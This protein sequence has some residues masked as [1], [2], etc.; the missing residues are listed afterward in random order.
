MVKAEDLPESGIYPYYTG[1]Y[2][3]RTYSFRGKKPGLSRD[4]Y[5]K[6]AGGYNTIKISRCRMGG[7]AHGSSGY[8]RDKS[9]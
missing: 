9:R 5:L 8:E 2:A 7:N 3:V 4:R 6:R 1:K